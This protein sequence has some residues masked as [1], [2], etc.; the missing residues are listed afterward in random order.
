MKQGK[1]NPDIVRSKSH[2]QSKTYRTSILRKS[3]GTVYFL[4]ATQKID[5][6]QFI[7]FV[8]KSGLIQKDEKFDLVNLDGGSSTALRSPALKFNANKKLPLFIG[9]K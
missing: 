1:I 7:V 9:I 2:W 4:V 8:Y 6:P 3:D 5:L